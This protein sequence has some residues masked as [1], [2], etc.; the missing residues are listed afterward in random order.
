LSREKQT[1]EVLA[2]AKEYAE[3]ALDWLI[4]DQ[5]ISFAI[6]T[7]S[8]VRRGLMGIDIALVRSGGDPVNFTFNKAWEAS[9]AI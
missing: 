7:T 8:W 4:Q 9:R 2:R 1:A 5:V 6:V 3:E